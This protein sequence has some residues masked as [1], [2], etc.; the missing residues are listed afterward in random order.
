MAQIKIYMYA[1]VRSVYPSLSLRVCPSLSSGLLL[2]LMHLAC[3]TRITC[4]FATPN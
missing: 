4:A 2:L 1:S 3:F